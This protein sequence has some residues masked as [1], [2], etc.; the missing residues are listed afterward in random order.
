VLSRPES[1]IA[2]SSLLETAAK[3]TLED[4]NIERNYDVCI[5]I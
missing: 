1:A 3:A 2:A 4:E 5:F